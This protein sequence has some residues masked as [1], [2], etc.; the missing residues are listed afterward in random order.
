MNCPEVS[1]II[2]N[3]NYSKYLSICIESCIQQ[4]GFSNY[5]IIIVDD[6]STDSSIELIKPFVGGKV[7]LIE[8][9]NGGIES[10]SNEGI[11]QAKGEYVVRLDADDYLFPDFLHTLMAVMSDRNIAFAYSNYL[12]VNG[13]GGELYAESLPEFAVQEICTRGDFLATGT[14]YR[15]SEILEVGCY[16]ESKIN[17]GLE[18]YELILKLLH[19]GSKG[20]HV[21]QQLF[22]YRRHGMNV[23]DIR[24]NEI[25]SYGHELFSRMGL[26]RYRTNSHHP[27]QLKVVNE[28]NSDSRSTS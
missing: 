28:Q 25:I 24:K 9:N 8:R 5:E 12:V 15:K 17:C 3:Y 20:V 11:A 23:S 13:D 7:R 2:T 4:T 27:Y 26:G 22:A 16:N 19:K 6:G 18:N 14:I 1:I 21:P 10:A